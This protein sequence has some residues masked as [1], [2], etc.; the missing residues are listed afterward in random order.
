M[1]TENLSTLKIHKLTQAQYE[2]EV[3]NGTIDENAL[4]LTPDEEVDL[5]AY[6]TIEQLNGKANSTHTHTIANITNLQS[7]LDGKANSSHTH[8]EY[9][10][11]IDPTGTGSFSMNRSPNYEAG[12]C[13]FAIGYN[14][15]PSGDYSCAEGNGTLASGTQSHAE[16][17]EAKAFGAASH[18][19][20][21][22]TNANGE[23]SHAEGYYTTALDFQHAQGHYNNTTKATAGTSEGTG[24]GT[25]FVIGNGTSSSTSN[26]F[27]VDYAGKPYSKSTI[28]STG[29]DYAEFFEWQDLNPDSEDRRGYFVTID[30]DKIKIAEP[31]DY[32]LGIVSG[33]P[34]IVGNAD[35]DWMGRYIFDEFGDFIYEE[36]EYEATVFD[37]ETG[38]TKTITK[39]GTK[40]KENP[41]YDPT[42]SYVHREYRPEWDAVG[43]M[44]VL[45]V[46]DDGTCQVNGYCKVADGGIATASESGYRVIKRINENIVKV[47][48]R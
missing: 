29:A 9:M 10:D 33:R 46:K 2:R 3:A 47:I 28:N 5:S 7:T 8:D 12:E 18:A 26:A 48:F 30:E 11:S 40:Y 43:M 38:E 21:A 19:E 4:Y 45:S 13:S 15:S 17:L 44:G 36:F 23:C 31:N 34:A 14:T 24:T 37:K 6:A 22:W 16:G 41:D 42:R 39:T 25:A 20:G 27:R 32:I 35:E 1:I